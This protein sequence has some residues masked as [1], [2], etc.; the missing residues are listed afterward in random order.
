[1]FIHRDYSRPVEDD[2]KLNVESWLSRDREAI[3]VFYEPEFSPVNED[4]SQ[5]TCPTLVG[6]HLQRKYE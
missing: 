6:W 2:F 3:P 4:P 5:S 1:M